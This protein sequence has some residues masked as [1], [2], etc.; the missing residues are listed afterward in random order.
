MANLAAYTQ[1]S[2]VLCSFQ[3]QKWNTYSHNQSL[4]SLPPDLQEW[5]SKFGKKNM[6]S[7]GRSEI[8]EGMKNKD[9]GKYVKLIVFWD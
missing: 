5:N 1:Q 7:H 8:L 2:W 6:F 9:N 4:V 3:E